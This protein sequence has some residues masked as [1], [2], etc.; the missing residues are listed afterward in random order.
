MMESNSQHA[1]SPRTAEML[2]PDSFDPL[3]AVAD[4]EQ[5]LYAFVRERPVTA[6]VAAL[7]IGFVVARMLSRR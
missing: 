4:L 7:G 5:Q 3:A 1:P 6:V 2:R